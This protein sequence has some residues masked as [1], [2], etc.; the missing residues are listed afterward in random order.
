MNFFF[1]HIPDSR[2]CHDT[3][4]LKQIGP[5]KGFAQGPNSGSLVVIGL[6]H[7]F[8]HQSATIVQWYY[9]SA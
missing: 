1:L 8:H 3:A 5:V 2:V 7:Q 6:E 9:H 4:P